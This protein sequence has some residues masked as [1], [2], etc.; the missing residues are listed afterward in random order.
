[1]RHVE[2][3]QLSATPQRGRL[4]AGVD[5]AA[6]L[7]YSARVG[8]R[9][10]QL[11]GELVTQTSVPSA[12]LLGFGS[13]VSFLGRKHRRFTARVSLV[14]VAVVG[15]VFS[16]LL[17]AEVPVMAANKPTATKPKTATTTKS[18]S[19]PSAKGAKASGKS[20]ATKGGKPKPKVTLGVVRQTRLQRDAVR[21]QA[22]KKAAQLQVTKANRAQAAAALA[23]LNSNVR[24]TSISLDKAQRNSTGARKELAQAESRLRTLEK[25]LDGLRSSQLDE[26]LK[27][28]G[29]PGGSSLDALLQSDSSSQASRR[30]SYGEIARRNTADLVDELAATSEDVRIERAKAAKARKRAAEVQAAVSARLIDFKQASEEQ[31]KLATVLEAKLER[32]LEEQA[33]LAELDKNFSNQLAKQNEQLTRQLLSAGAGRKGSGTFNVNGPDPSRS[34]NEV[35]G[36]SGGS[37]THGI[38]V[39]PSLRPRLVAMLA[40]AKA[41]GL[42]ITGG[43]YRSP[44]NQ[45]RLRAAHCGG[46]NYNVYHKPSSQC[47]P[48]TAR[49]G[50]SQHERG[51]A[52]DFSYGGQI[53]NRS[54]PGYKWLR[55]NAWRYGFINLKSEPWHWSTTGR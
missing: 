16:G 29:A 36:V 24:L 26:A 2:P 23:A 17:V 13:V 4:Q 53:F 35:S 54:S 3:T 47:H 39:A 15:M 38:R 25:R 30:A 28:Y 43:G 1:M 46:G 40:A 18:G 34:V 50:N 5:R 33:S 8:M 45:I 21:A 51:L 14:L 41:D 12:G 55:N 32:D 52:V 48:P 7:P 22:A 44:A 42:Y 11:S 31:L 9:P 10:E 37:D 19:K 20:S 49:P 27:Q 6:V